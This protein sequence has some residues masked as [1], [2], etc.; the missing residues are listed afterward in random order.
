MVQFGTFAPQGW[1]LEM[2]GIAGGARQWDTTK[3]VAQRLEQDGWDSLWLYDHFHTVPRVEIEPTFECWTT[4]AA[5]AMVALSLFWL[6]QS[7]PVQ[8]H[9]L[10]A[11]ALG[12]GLSVIVAGALMGLI[13]FS[14]RSGA[15]DDVGQGDE[16]DD[17]RHG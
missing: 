10:I 14:S 9:M 17:D 13:Y 1:R 2:K 4:M 12:V 11:T 7:G 8:I 3:R 5:L 6:W 16:D 15:D